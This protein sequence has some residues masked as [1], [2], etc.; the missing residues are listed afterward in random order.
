MIKDSCFCKLKKKKQI[1]WYY[2]YFFFQTMITH[3]YLIYTFGWFQWYYMA[4]FIIPK[5]EKIMIILFRSRT[6]LNSL[7]HNDCFTK[8]FCRTNPKKSKRHF[9]FHI[10]YG[11]W[12]RVKSRYCYI[13]SQN[14]IKFNVL[15]FFFFLI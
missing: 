12:C 10:W 5:I 15:H 1:E 4:S 11:F 7:K 13:I 9:V 6:I 3:P 8:I 14:K 2:I